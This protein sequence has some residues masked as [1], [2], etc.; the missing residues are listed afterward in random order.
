MPRYDADIDAIKRL[1]DALLEFAAQQTDAFAAA[2]REIAVAV[3]ADDERERDCR[4]ELERC[5]QELFN[6]YAAEV[7]TSVDCSSETIAVHEAEEKLEGAWRARARMEEAISVYRTARERLQSALENELPRARAYLEARITALEAY[8]ATNLA[9][10]GG[11]PAA[12]SGVVDAVRSSRG[13]L[14]AALG[15]TGEQAAVQVL[16]ERFGL[17]EVPSA[18]AAGGTER[19]LAAP[20]MPLVVIENREQDR[21]SAQ[22]PVG[23]RIAALVAETGLPAGPA[24]VVVIHVAS[25]RADVYARS[26]RA[27]WQQVQSGLVL[28]RQA[29][30]PPDDRGGAPA[31]ASRPNAGPAEEPR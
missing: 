24:M 11:A 7:V 27:G 31:E 12:M 8:A 25:R 2:D 17:V 19:V 5:R 13:E 4:A 9:G 29:L 10:G 14:I 23:R 21:P 20:G 15:D 1:N 3:Q 28:N 30:R 22:E 6:C 18:L 26:E 16:S